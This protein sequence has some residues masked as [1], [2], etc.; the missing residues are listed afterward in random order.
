MHILLSGVGRLRNWVSLL[1]LCATCALWASCDDSVLLVLNLDTSAVPPP[2]TTFVMRATLNGTI[3]NE[4]RV[5]A[6]QRRIAM[7]LPP[8]STGSVSFE[9]LGLEDGGCRY[10]FGG[11]IAQ[12]PGGLSNASEET[13]RLSPSSGR[14][15]WQKLSSPTSRNLYAMTGYGQTAYVVGDGGTL[16]RCT[17]TTCS[18]LE[19]GT[20]VDLRGV[21]VGAAGDVYAVGRTATVLRC[22]GGSGPCVTLPAGPSRDLR[23]VWGTAEGDVIA[24][25]DYGTFAICKAGMPSC[26]AGSYGAISDFRKVFGSD[27]SNVYI[28]GTNGYVLRCELTSTYGS[29]DQLAT[30]VSDELR[31]I[32]TSVTGGVSSA[33][34]MGDDG[35]ILR[36]TQGQGGCLSLSGQYTG[37]LFDAVATSPT[38]IHGVGEPGTVLRCTGQPGTCEA[39]TTRSTSSLRAVWGLPDT[40][41]YA[42]GA[43]GALIVCP[44]ASASCAAQAS[45]TQVTLTA[46]WGSDAK[47][48]YV[49]G[50]AG[51]LLRRY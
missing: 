50:E 30:G 21:W 25:G 23:S 41:V 40:D 35:L 18:T 22:P 37:A 38:T 15:C 4:L 48:L 42:V 20:S 5:P 24:V 31:A 36:C 49:A 51:T 34:I 6:S 11:A 16:L 45:G 28:A 3:G 27:R 32:A 17:G 1:L 46:I 10:D 14:R 12:V 8:G 9:I 47:N 7:H 26:N 19:T 13:I 2:V 29:C 44:G 33:L 39:L 43:G